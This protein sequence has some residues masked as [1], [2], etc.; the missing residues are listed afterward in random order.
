MHTSDAMLDSEQTL[1]TE[2]GFAVAINLFTS[3]D[4]DHDDDC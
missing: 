2:T 4:D 3:T 1:T